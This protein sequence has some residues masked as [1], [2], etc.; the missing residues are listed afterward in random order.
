MLGDGK[1]INF[2]QPI[3]QH[4][5]QPIVTSLN[6]SNSIGLSLKALI[7]DFIENH[8][9]NLPEWFNPKGPCYSCE[10]HSDY[11]PLF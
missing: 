4:W 2:W 9:W 8:S 1:N 5:S 10:N 11:H 7:A 6:L 3:Q